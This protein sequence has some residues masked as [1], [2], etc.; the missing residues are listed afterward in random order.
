MRIFLGSHEG[1]GKNQQTK[2]IHDTATPFQNVYIPLY[3]D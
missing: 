1:K 2:Y 3:T